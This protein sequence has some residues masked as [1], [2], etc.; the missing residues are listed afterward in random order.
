[1][2]SKNFDSMWV[3]VAV[4]ANLAAGL[5]AVWWWRGTGKSGRRGGGKGTKKSLLHTPGVRVVCFQ[6]S[7]TE[8]SNDGWQSSGNGGRSKGNE[9]SKWEQSKQKG[10]LGYYFAHHITMKELAPEDYQMNGPR[11]LSKG[12]PA[13]S[14]A[15]TNGGSAYNGSSPP[16]TTKRPRP[17][18]ITSYSW[19]DYGEEVRL[20]FRQSGW[21][22]A[23][24][25]AK[26]I[27]VEWG[28]RRFRMSIDSREYGLHAIDLQRLNGDV[29][30]VRVRKLKSR[31]VVALVK[32]KRGSYSR[33]SPWTRLQAAPEK[34]SD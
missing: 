25:E 1:M 16:T 17:Q 5:L 15:A 9:A 6:D 28:P 2:P 29:D 26:E 12:D 23:K 3:I 30:G 31:L 11:L 8:S 7:S 22:W 4:A 32:A 24:V 27:G 20:T 19:E 14:T 21:E 34:S 33:T 10:S 18:Q 13:A